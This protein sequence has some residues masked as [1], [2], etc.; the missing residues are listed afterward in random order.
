MNSPVPQYAESVVNWASGVP[1]SIKVYL[2][3]SRINGT[4]RD[5]SDLDIALEFKDEEEIKDRVH[6]WFK[7]HSYWEKQL[8]RLLPCKVHLCLYDGEQYYKKQKKTDFLTTEEYH[9]IFDSANVLS[10][11]EGKPKQRSSRKKKSQ[12]D[13]RVQTSSP[14]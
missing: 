12:H 3:G 13:N 4:P 9:L 10:E 1:Y 14:E 6:L 2:F 5:D 11:K 7:F 8:T